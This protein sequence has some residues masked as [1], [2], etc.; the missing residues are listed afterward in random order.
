MNIAMLSYH[1]SPLA[2][3]GGKHSGGMNVYVRELSAQL[4]RIGHRVDIFTRGV[5]ASEEVTAPGVRLISLPAGPRREVPKNELAAYIPE[6]AAAVLSFQQAEGIEYELIHAHYWMSGLVGARLKAAWKIPMLLMFHTLGLVKNRIAV[7]GERESD[8]RILGERRAMAAADMVVAATPAEQADLQWL[9]EVHTD[10]ICVVPP[11]VDLDLFR[12]LDK[13]QAREE[14]G[15]AADE[16]LLLFVGRIEALKG[17][18]T[19]IRA[20]HLMSSQGSPGGRKFRVRVVGGDVEEDL[21]ILESEMARLRTL[22]R[23]LGM[24]NFIEFLG[25]RRQRD[26]PSYYAAADVVV[27]PSYSESFGMVALEAMACGRPVVASRVGG[28]AYLVQDG[29]TGFHVQE[30]NPG[31]L[32]G[33]LVEL[34]ANEELLEKMGQAARREAEKYSWERAA[35]GIEGIYKKLVMANS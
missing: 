22:A 31:E 8:A 18:D 34:L 23:E 15:L 13:K 5:A 17:I 24:Q 14:L 32:A 7:L 20:A 26:L 25:S 2:A 1:T 33:R 19:L 35:M 10:R 28:L 11:G 3:L 12:P 29:L 30:G 9:Y 4:A 27:M 21:E 6:F 16:S